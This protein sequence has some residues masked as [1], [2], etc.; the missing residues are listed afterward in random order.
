MA[1][2]RLPPPDL[3]PELEPLLRQA[4]E[5]PPDERDAFLR[6]ACK[7]N[8]RLGAAARD[9]L[10]ADGEARSFLAAP[11]DLGVLVAGEAGLAE[12]DQPTSEAPA[13]TSI[14]PYRVIREIGRGGMGVVY[15]AE[16]Q[17]PRRPVALK[18]ILGGPY[19]DAGAV[20]MFRREADSLA[21]LKHPASR[22]RVGTS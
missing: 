19:V 2:A 20:R 1:D 13:G 10:I 7:E 5:R 3:W 12:R 15:E 17:Q 4:L 9:L 18:V 22:P 16:Q 11:L 8:A 6:E 21:R 14:G